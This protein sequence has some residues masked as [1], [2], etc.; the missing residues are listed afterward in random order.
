[1]LNLRSKIYWSMF[2]Y[3]V[4]CILNFSEGVSEHQLFF[5]HPKFEVKKF[6][7]FFH[8]HSS[9]DSEFVKG[10]VWSPTFFGYIKFEV[11]I[12]K[13]FFVC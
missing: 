12:F 7:E 2:I 6:S 9:L 10:E 11:K 3:R 13:N 1:M 5:G 8:L 4:L